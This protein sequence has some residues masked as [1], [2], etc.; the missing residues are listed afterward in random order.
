MNEEAANGRT[1]LHEASVIG[2]SEM[3]ELLIHKGADVLSRD[4]SGFTPYELAFRKGHKDVC[5][6][7][8]P[9][10]YIHC[11]CSLIFTLNFPT[12]R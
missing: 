10:A 9:S 7:D 2:D 11:L 4:N 1:S 5:N 8:L 6:E 12:C 3:V